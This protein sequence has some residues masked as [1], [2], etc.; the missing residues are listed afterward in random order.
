MARSFNGSN[1]YIETSSFPNA[2]LPVTMSA[3]FY[4][5]STSGFQ[6]VSVW[7]SPG[8]GQAA[9]SL[10]LNYP[11]AGQLSNQVYKG[12]TNVLPT[13]SGT[14]TTNAWNH[15]AVVSGAT[16]ARCY[17]NGS[18]G[19]DA[20]YVALTFS[21]CTILGVGRVQNTQFL[22][23]RVAELGV[24]NVELTA[25]EIAA[26]AKGYTPLEIRPDALL[27][28]YPLGGHYGQLDLDRWKNRYDLTPANS[29]TWVDHPRV[30]YP[31]PGV[32]PLTTATG[33]GGGGGSPLTSWWAWNQFGTP[34]DH[35]A[36]N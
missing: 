16:A 17:L 3:W 8:G 32:W 9:A 21:S 5:A 36:R 28:Y 4:P 14:F 10:L 12:G 2:S 1:Q 26:L 33:G 22:N 31:P 30:I 7:S 35:G 18:V 11:G 20:T 34:L 6:R 29:P 27:A 24:W 25:A 23:G 15:G 19:S 13:G